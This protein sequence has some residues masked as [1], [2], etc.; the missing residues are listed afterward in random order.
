MRW[1]LLALMCSASLASAQT[2]DASGLSP[3]PSVESDAAET[4][5]DSDPQTDTE[6][7]SPDADDE[8]Q[9]S[10]TIGDDTYRA[11]GTNVVRSR[12]GRVV[13]VS[14]LDVEPTDLFERNGE[15]WFAVGD[16]AAALS[17]YSPRTQV[18]EP[19]RAT[20]PTPPRTTPIEPVRPPFDGPADL[21]P[22]GRFRDRIAP[23][24]VPGVSLGLSVMPVLGGGFA[25]MGDAFVAVRARRAF[26]AR[27]VVDRIGHTISAEDGPEFGIF[28]GSL[29]LG[30]DHRYF[31]M[32]FGV[33]LTHARIDD[34]TRRLNGIAPTFVMGMRF[35]A[36]DGLH[37]EVSSSLVAAQ[38]ETDFS[39][40][41]VR[42]QWPLTVG[43]WLV[44]RGAGSGPSG[45]GW[46]EIGMRILTHGQRDS[47]SLFITP[48]IGGGGL[49]DNT[50][51]GRASGFAM[52]LGIEYRP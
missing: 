9:A 28:D 33:G 12:G 27:L 26:S 25:I 18:P 29:S 46:G 50:S 43:R 19:P 4:E 2:E 40:I 37:V 13:G 21:D 38:G 36:L 47:G 17:G 42:M 41:A 35:G 15:A 39:K 31:E 44:V 23:E 6:T 7:E 51:F 3:D 34:F 30:Y 24:R 14:D 48:S 22:N 11:C 8:C 49:F 32:S 16:R 1:L 20:V 5:T 52:S 10:L 45:Y